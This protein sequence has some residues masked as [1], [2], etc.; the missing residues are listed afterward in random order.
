[1]R[2][3][4]K[5]KHAA[6]KSTARKVRLGL[7]AIAMGVTGSAIA[8]SAPTALAKVPAS[9]EGR[10]QAQIGTASWYGGRFNGRKTASGERFD[11]NAFTCAHRTLPLGSWL[12]VTNLS[13]LKSIFLRVN[14]RGPV[15]RS[16]ILDLSRGAARMLGIT[17]LGK[18]EIEPIRSDDT[19]MA[20]D[21]SP[22]VLSEI[23]RVP[24]RAVRIS[25]LPD[26]PVLVAAR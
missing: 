20:D 17:G 8:S 10:G 5:Q 6:R 21:M 24:L 25:V 22:T 2:R 16:R 18:V 15:P 12:R 3:N 4:A 9:N 11:M 13:N 23:F 1:M 14:D 26:V 7:M 19:D